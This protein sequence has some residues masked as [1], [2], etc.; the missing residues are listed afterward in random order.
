MS[1]RTLKVV[2]ALLLL[3]SLA[4]PQS[5][6]RHYEDAKA[7]RVEHKTGDPPPAGA[8][9]VVRYNYAWES[10]EPVDP[11][12]W[13]TVLAFVWPVLTLGLLLRPEKRRAALFLRLL[14]ILLLAASFVV[15]DLSGGLFADRL[16]AGYYLAMLA[17]V[18]YAAGTLWGDLAAFRQWRRTRRP[19]LAPA[20]S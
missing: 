18:L 4:L 12:T 3:I 6:C 17:L 7:N 1:H 9:E 5:S 20:P 8:H 13:L 10:F 2:G 16:E 19:R 14:E 11:S 15:V